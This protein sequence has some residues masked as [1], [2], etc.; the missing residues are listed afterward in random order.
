MQE[1][2]SGWGGDKEKGGEEKLKTRQI[3]HPH[4]C[5]FFLFFFVLLFLKKCSFSFFLL[6][7]LK[8]WKYSFD[9][10]NWRLKIRRF[11]SFNPG[12]YWNKSSKF[13]D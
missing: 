12:F 2:T 3:H 7:P 10:G 6:F 8:H 4:F 5:F 13:A 9:S 1:L 11:S